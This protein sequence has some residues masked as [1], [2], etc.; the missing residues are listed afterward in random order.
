M[1]RGEFPL[2]VEVI[3]RA[4][5][6]IL[7]SAEER[8]WVLAALGSRLD[9]GRLHVLDG[10][11]PKRDWLDAAPPD[12]RLSDNDGQIHT[13]LVGRPYGM[14][15]DLRSGLARRAIRLHEPSGI[16]PG[17]WVSRLGRYDA[18]WLHPVRAENGG[19][20]R[21]ATWDDLNLPARIPTLLAAG[22]PLIV[23]APA[24]GSVHAASRLARDLGCGVLYDDLD[25]LIGQLRDS[26]IMEVRRAAAWS[27]RET[28]TFDHHADRLLNILERAAARA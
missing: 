12:G 4:N 3:Q 1:A 13:V 23:P 21:A 15:G 18:G 11:L 16:E 26:H 2:L 7:S 17:D 10:D 6:V 25:D 24:P 20:I 14:D 19:E 9:P 28:L 8:D 22:L 5:E 27:A